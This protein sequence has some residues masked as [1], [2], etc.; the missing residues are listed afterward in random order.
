MR[1][2]DYTGSPIDGDDELAEIEDLGLYEF[3]A[4]KDVLDFDVDDD[5]E[6]V[7]HFGSVANGASTLRAAA[8]LLYDFADELLELSGEGWEIVDDVTN[9]HAT[10]VRFEVDEEPGTDDDG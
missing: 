7:I 1:E 2:N 6:Q 10:A 3:D 4:D 8:E 5:S 9:G